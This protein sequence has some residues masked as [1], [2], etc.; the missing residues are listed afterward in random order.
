MDAV[1]VQTEELIAAVRNSRDYRRYEKSKELLRQRPELKKKVDEYRIR[2]FQMQ[3]A[4]RDLYD[5]SD[6]MLREFDS[7]LQDPLAAE[8]LDS[9]SAVC[10]MVQR[11]FNYISKS[12]AVDLPGTRES[13]Q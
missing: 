10:R 12:L 2:N 9:E 1:A 8:Y 7:T 13:R 11:V 3:Q 5:E 6:E 4:G